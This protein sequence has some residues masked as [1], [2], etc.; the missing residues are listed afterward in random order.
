LFVPIL[1]GLLVILVSFG[2]KSY[3]R[4]RLYLP[5]RSCFTL[6]APAAFCSI[7]AASLTA[8]VETTDNYPY[9]HRWPKL[10]WID[11]LESSFLNGFLCLLEK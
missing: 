9:I 5:N 10:D 7:L 2:V 6:L 8:F 4:K 1:L 11:N 3:Q